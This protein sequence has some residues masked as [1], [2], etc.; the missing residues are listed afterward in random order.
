MRYATAGLKATDITIGNKAVPVVL[1]PNTPIN[2]L[3]DLL[4]S[5]ISSPVQIGELG[6][7]PILLNEVVEPVVGKPSPLCSA[8]TVCLLFT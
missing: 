2:S 3:D 7:D 8:T 4:Y 6:K 5:K 1:R